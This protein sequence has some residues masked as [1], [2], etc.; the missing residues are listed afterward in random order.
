MGGMQAS[1]GMV[2]RDFSSQSLLVAPS[3][4]IAPLS[5]QRQT[6]SQPREWG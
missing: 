3:L 5:M 1:E 2:S 6:L 4:D